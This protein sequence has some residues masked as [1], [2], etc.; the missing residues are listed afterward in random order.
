MYILEIKHTDSRVSDK[1]SDD[2]DGVM[3]R[4]FSFFDNH[5]IWS[6]NK[7]CDGLGIFALFNNKHSFFCSS[8]VDFSNNTGRTEFFSC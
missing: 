3:E 8:Q 1:I 7:N 2:T 5:A 4:S 6:A